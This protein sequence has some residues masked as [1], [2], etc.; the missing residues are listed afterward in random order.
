MNNENWQHLQAA[1]ALA[2]NSIVIYHGG[3][4]DGVGAAWVFKHF[5]GSQVELFEGVYNKAAPSCKGRDVYFVDFCYSAEVMEAICKE[6]NMVTLIDHHESSLNAMQGF[7]VLRNFD[8]SGSSLTR[9]GAA[10]AWIWAT[11][12]SL[13]TQ[14][15][16]AFLL[17][18]EDRDLWRFQL[19]NTK[20]VM[21]YFFSGDISIER[22]NQM[23]V[24]MEDKN[25]WEPIVATGLALMAQ[26]NNTV[27]KIIDN[28]ARRAVIDGYNV[29]LLNC[30]YMFSSDIG[31]LMSIDEP[32]AVM[33]EDNATHRSFSLRSQKEGGMNVANIAKQFGG[34]GHPNAAGFKVNRDHPL[35]KI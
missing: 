15:V 4:S 27:S 20:A 2:D 22:V 6:A 11:G 26:F 17:H 33:Y 30:N 23:I 19:E 7:K 12:Q 21:Q 18:V 31:N 25:D 13:D 10:L 29:P 8:M 24:A 16:P 14:A 32:F 9:S 35:A 28:T 3:C 34:G 5:F 1:R